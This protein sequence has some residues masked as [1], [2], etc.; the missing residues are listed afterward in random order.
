MLLEVLL[1]P[2]Q[3]SAPEAFV[4]IE[5]LARTRK[6]IGL[7][8]AAPVL[9]IAFA[10]DERGFFEHLQMPRDGGKRN[11]EGLRQIAHGRVSGGQPRQDRAAGRVGEGG[12]GGVAVYHL[13][14]MLINWFVKFN[15][16]NDPYT[17]SC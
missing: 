15:G 13:T 6:R 7:Q 10:F 8:A 12:K 2:V 3:R 16:E 9:A 17:D 4:Q 5:P 14:T 11:P 1:Q